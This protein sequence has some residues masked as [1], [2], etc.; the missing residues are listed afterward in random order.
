[1]N[2]TNPEIVGNASQQPYMTN[3]AFAHH[4]RVMTLHHG[5]RIL[6]EVPTALRRFGILLLVLTISLPIFMAALIVVLWRL[7]G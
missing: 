2:G 4:A 3:A 6:A 1:L 7:A 5:E